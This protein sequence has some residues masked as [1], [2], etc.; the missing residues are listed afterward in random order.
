MKVVVYSHDA[1]VRARI[2]LAIGRRPAADVP[3]AEVTEV[4]THAALIRLL[5]A[6][7]ADARQPIGTLDI[8]SSEERHTILREW[9]DTAR[10]APTATLPELLAAQ[11]RKAGGEPSVLAIA[12]DEKTRLRS[13]IEQGLKSDLLLLSGGVSVGRYDFVEQVLEDLDAEFFFTGAFIQPGR[14]VVFGRVRETY[15]LSS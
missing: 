9:N 7:I 12:P 15:I 10:A 8:L 4:A 2:R 1:D 6:A 13:L 3:E 14:P 5:E 11:V